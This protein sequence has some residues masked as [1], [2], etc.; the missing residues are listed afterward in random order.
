MFERVIS[1]GLRFFLQAEDGIR[2]LTVTGVQTCALPISR[3]SSPESDFE[4][5]GELRR[6]ARALCRSLCE[7][8]GRASCRESVASS[9][10]AVAIKRK[11]WSLSRHVQP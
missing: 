7:Q 9:R 5:A 10:A 3:R 4:Y 1:F 6:G 8:I 11:S 2:Y